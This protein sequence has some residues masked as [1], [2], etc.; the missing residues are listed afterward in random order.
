MK[1]LWGALYDPKIDLQKK[2]P[3][4][5]SKSGVSCGCMQV[6]AKGLYGAFLPGHQAD[7]IAP[8]PTV[9]PQS[10]PFCT[11]EAFV[12]HPGKQQPVV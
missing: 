7:A 6:A 5:W 4:R 2:W 10:E 1:P 9:L 3:L 11:P 8:A 12:V